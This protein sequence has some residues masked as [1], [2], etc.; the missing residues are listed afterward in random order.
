MMLKCSGDWSSGCDV[1]GVSCEIL[2]FR[3]LKKRVPF[4]TATFAHA[5]ENVQ[6]NLNLRKFNLG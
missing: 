4:P 6:M 5:L 2:E 3:D 1:H